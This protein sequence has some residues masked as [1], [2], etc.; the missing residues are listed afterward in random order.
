MNRMLRRNKKSLKYAELLGVRTKTKTDKQGNV[1]KTGEKESYYSEPIDFKANIVMSGG[2][3]DMVEFGLNL[4]DYSA[5]IVVPKDS[6]PIKEGWLIWDESEPVI[7]DGN[8]LETSADYVV[9]K[10]SPTPNVDKFILQR[11]VH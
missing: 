7:V 5:K 4:A 6:L 8:S 11:L 10:K 1:V 3:A 9:V 2:N